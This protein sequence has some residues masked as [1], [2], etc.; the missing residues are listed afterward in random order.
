MAL[1][2]SSGF[3]IYLSFMEDIWQFSADPSEEAHTY[4]L[5]KCNLEVWY[6]KTTWVTPKSLY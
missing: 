1:S 6:Q 3:S 4:E 2:I 5:I